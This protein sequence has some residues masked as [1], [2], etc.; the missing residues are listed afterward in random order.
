[1]KNNTHYKLNGPAGCKPAQPKIKR[2]SAGPL[3]GKRS[4]GHPK[5][6]KDTR[7]EK[8]NADIAARVSRGI[9]TYQEIGADYGLS[10]E[11]VR[12]VAQ[13]LLPRTGIRRVSWHPMIYGTCPRCQR[14]LTKKQ[15]DGSRHPCPVDLRNELCGRCR[16]EFYDRP[17]VLSCRCGKTKTMKYGRIR[18]EQQYSV[19]LGYTMGYRRVNANGRTGVYLCHRCWYASM[20]LHGVGN[21]L[22]RRYKEAERI[23]KQTRQAEAPLCGAVG[24]A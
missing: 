14:S 23:F 17:V 6:T 1:M 19:K 21:G 8:R 24:K 16:R 10:R 13:G 15:T 4:P 22:K 9:E 18:W 2:R 20:R 3:P 12:Q 11:R 5:G 7:L